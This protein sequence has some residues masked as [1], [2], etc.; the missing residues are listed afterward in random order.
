MRIRIH[1]EGVFKSLL[2]LV[3]VLLFMNILGLISSFYLGHGRLHGLIALFNFDS[4]KNIPTL[5][6]SLALLFS[7]ALLSIIAFIHKRN[8]SAY[9]YWLGLA[10]IF[11]FL[12]ID[13]TSSIHERL[14][15]PVRESLHT[16]GALFFAWVIPYGIALII[17]IATYLKFLIGLPKKIMVLFIISGATFVSGAIGFE[18]LGGWQA[19]LS[20]T[21]NNL[22]Y[23]IFY[24]C[25]ESLEML[26]IVIFIYTLLTY[27]VSQFKPLTLTVIPS[28]VISPTKQDNTAQS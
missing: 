23:S 6:S 7:S 2:C 25:E 27:M 10:I 11:L 24:T 8:G 28:R 4:E 26:G 16:S 9:Y 19:D 18:L 5:Y 12:S 15:I 22:V 17:F 21:D 20:G 14:I 1:P 13:E 3:S